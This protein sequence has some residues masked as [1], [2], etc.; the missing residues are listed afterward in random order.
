M[1]PRALA[2]GLAT[3]RLAL[4][5]AMFVAPS[6]AVGAWLG[7][8]AQRPGAKAAIRGLGARDVA[9]AVGALVALRDDGAGASRWLEAGVLA[10]G[11]DVTASLLAGEGVTRWLGVTAGG[12]AAVAGLWLRDRVG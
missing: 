9:L 12:G 7:E 11:G 2:R 3:A 10:D 4:G 8:D 6:R 5:L 1:D